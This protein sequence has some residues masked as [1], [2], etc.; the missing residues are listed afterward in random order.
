MS[1]G[2]QVI[3][4]HAHAINDIEFSFHWI[5]R[6]KRADEFM[7]VLN[8][9]EI[10]KEEKKIFFFWCAFCSLSFRK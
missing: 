10:W 7:V 1:D 4:E 2:I 3:H 6:I 8:L 9:I 5:N